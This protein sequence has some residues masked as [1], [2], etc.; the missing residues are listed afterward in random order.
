MRAV[1]GTSFY[2]VPFRRYSI[3][4]I[5]LSVVATFSSPNNQSSA[6][7]YS[8]LSE[9]FNNK[10]S[11]L[12]TENGNLFVLLKKKIPCHVN[13]IQQ[14]V[15]FLLFVFSFFLRQPFLPFSSKCCTFTCTLKL[16]QLVLLPQTIFC[17]SVELLCF[18]FSSHIFKMQ[19]MT[20][21]YST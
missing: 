10:L 12:K 18:S 14:L 15:F 4:S 11:L 1:V 20:V 13:H 19:F 5:F 8:R 7:T 2:L 16:S 3:M 17:Q 6:V 9:T 21:Y